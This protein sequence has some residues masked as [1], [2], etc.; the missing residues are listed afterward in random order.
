MEKRDASVVAALLQTHDTDKL[1][2]LSQ[3]IA[4]S[5]GKDLADL[6]AAVSP[7]EPSVN[8][9]IQ[10]LVQVCHAQQVRH[11]A[12]LKLNMTW[13]VPMLH[14]A[15]Y[16]IRKCVEQ[17]SLVQKQKVSHTALSC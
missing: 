8:L 9:L 4:G 10:R 11:P 13:M 2:E 17:A 7:L 12:V 3:P 6:I 15:D 1:A 14:C 16:S 5:S